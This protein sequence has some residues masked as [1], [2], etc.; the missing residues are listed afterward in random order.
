MKEYFAEDFQLVPIRGQKPL[1]VLKPKLVGSRGMNVD[2]TMVAFKTETCHHC[3]NLDIVYN[4]LARKVEGVGFDIVYLNKRNNMTIAQ[5][6]NQTPFQITGVPRMILFVNGVAYNQFP[7]GVSRD[8]NTIV[9]FLQEQINGDKD[10][11]RQFVSFIRGVGDLEGSA[12][13]MAAPAAPKSEAEMTAR[14]LS[15]ESMGCPVFKSGD[16]YCN[17]MYTVVCDDNSCQL[18]Y[19][20]MC[21]M[22]PSLP[23]N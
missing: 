23:A 13:R 2:L 3:K 22:N 6:A 1:L 5:M 4:E 8:F 20:Q 17:G 14:K 18:T 7:T 21:K 19:D 9:R 10:R 15:H 11:L 12:G 16:E